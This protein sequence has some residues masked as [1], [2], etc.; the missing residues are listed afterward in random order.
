[1]GTPAVEPGAVTLPAGTALPYTVARYD[2]TQ[3]QSLLDWTPTAA[4]EL[5]QLISFIVRV[6]LETELCATLTTAAGTAD[7]FEAAETTIG[8]AWPAGPDLILCAGPDLPKVRRA[9][10]EAFPNPQDR[11]A[12]KGTA[13][14]AAGTALVGRVIQD[15]ASLL[16]CLPFSHTEL[17]EASRLATDPRAHLPLFRRPA[18]ASTNEPQTS[19]QVWSWARPARGHAARRPPEL[20]PM[21]ATGVA[22]RL[23]GH[24]PVGLDELPKFGRVI[25]DRGTEPTAR[26]PFLFASVPRPHVFMPGSPCC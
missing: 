5:E 6:G 8:A 16:L 2:T 26:Q 22:V 17:T 13:G 18:S 15:N 4:I 23:L 19:S 12:I 24:D 21:G 11:P 20:T 3:S 1:M 9:Y 10:A 25:A 14:L 7:T